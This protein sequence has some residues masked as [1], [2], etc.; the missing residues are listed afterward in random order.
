ME[1]ETQFADVILPACTSLERNDIAEWANCSGYIPD[2]HNATNHR[3][4]VYQK[5]CLEPLGESKSDYDIFSA[6][7]YRLGFGDTYTEKNTEEDWIEKLFQK[8]AMADHVSFEGFRE[9]GYFVVPHP[10]GYERKPLLRDFHEKGVGVRTPSGRIEFASNTLKTHTTP[11]EERPVVPKY[12]PSW[13]GHESDAASTYPLQLLSPHPRYD[14]HTHNDAHAIWLAEI[15]GHRVLKDGRYWWPIRIH[16]KDATP[17]G[18]KDLDIVE[19][20]ND[21]GSVL[22]IARV[23]ERIRPGVVHAYESSGRYD[24][25]EPGSPGSRDRGGCVN[26]LTPSKKMSRKAPGMA[27]NSCLVD[28]RKWKGE[29]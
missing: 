9:R 17:R 29:S 6:L 14:F 22:L 18:I 11:E 12:V 10:D 2:S 3:V 28:V 7:A 1:G 25:E 20:F 21:R 4:I 26:L 16:P 27:P 23:T 19:A 24:P 8:T 5:K 13:E 15:P